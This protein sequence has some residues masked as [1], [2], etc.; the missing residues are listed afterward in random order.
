MSIPYLTDE[1]PAS[2]N[3]LLVDD[4]PELQ[5]ALAEYLCRSGYEVTAAAGGAAGLQLLIDARPDLILA[6][7][8][9]AEMDGFEFQRR[10]NGL[11]GNSIPLIFVTEQGDRESRLAALRAG[12]DDYVVK[13]YDLEELEA[14][15]AAVLARVE[16]TRREERRD[17]GTLRSRILSEVSRELRAPVSSI[18]AHLNLLLSQRFGEDQAR[19]KRYL[20]SAMA[21][22][23]TLRELVDD[24][25]WATAETPSGLSVRREPIRVAPVIRGAAASAALRASM[26]QVELRISCG[27]LLSANMDG[28]AMGRVLSEILDTAVEVSPP[29]SEVRLSAARSREGGVEFVIEDGGLSDETPP[30][31]QAELGSGSL[32]FA[33]RVVKGHGGRFSVQRKTDGR[34]SIAIWLPGRVAKS[35][36][37]RR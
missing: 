29:H 3:L 18:M 20:N 2:R 34:Q 26:R 27:G 32:D 4:A 36:S 16:Q 25:S 9:M 7:V 5:Q 12:A 10:A 24:L 37:C 28:E 21:D 33:R 13:P 11:T 22:A 35:V 14:R 31:A 1:G 19:L 17:I 6:D 8:R 23:H 30:D 15:I